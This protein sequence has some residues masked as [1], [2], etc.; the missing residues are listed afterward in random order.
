MRLVDKW[1]CSQPAECKKNRRLRFHAATL[2]CAYAKDNFITFRVC[3]I[4]RRLRPV[5]LSTQLNLSVIPKK[6][7]KPCSKPGRRGRTQHAARRLQERNLIHQGFKEEI[8][9]DDTQQRSDPKDTN[10]KG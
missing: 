7:R 6:K 4:A 9:E 5:Y 10:D 1:W 3:E 8:L 2:H